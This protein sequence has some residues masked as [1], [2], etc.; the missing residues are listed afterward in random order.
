MS[1][2]A[3]DFHEVLNEELK[4]IA[5]RREV[6][7]VLSRSGTA[8]EAAG[9]TGRSASASEPP[10]KSN[11]ESVLSA[12]AAA[13]AGSSAGKNPKP[14]EASPP[15]S[16][17]PNEREQQTK[18]VL[19]DIR[20]S[21]DRALEMNLFGLAFSG[22]GIRSA[23]FNLGVIQRLA[24]HGLIRHIDYLSTVSGGGYI[25]S[26]LMAWMAREGQSTGLAEGE[27]VRNVELQL[28]PSRKTQARAER[29][30]IPQETAVP[31]EPEPV[32]HL[33]EY[34]NYL[35]PK[36]GFLSADSW[37]LIAIYLRNLLLNQL[38]LLFWAILVTLAIRTVVRAF[39]IAPIDS[40]AWLAASALV[41][42][43]AMAFYR[44][45]D[46]LMSVAD[47]RRTR[48]GIS[49]V[50]LHFFILI[51]LLLAS[52][53]MTWLLSVGAKVD[54]WGW[55]DPLLTNLDGDYTRGFVKRSADLWLSLRPSSNSWAVCPLY[56][57]SFG[58]LHG[59]INLVI[60]LRRRDVLKDKHRGR[61]AILALAGF[62][63]GIIGGLLVYL[64]CTRL[65]WPA[66]GEQFAPALLATI[67]PPLML[68]IFV[69]GAY[70]EVGLASVELGEAER[71]WWSRVCAWC[72]IYAVSWLLVIGISTFGLVG[73]AWIA[74]RL[75]QY[76]GTVW[77]V[78]TL[79]WLATTITGAF[80]GK[81]PET[82]DGR[83][84][85]GLEFVAMI[86][87]Y[88]FLVGLSIF[89][90]WLVSA[91][92]EGLPVHDRL[93]KSLNHPSI[94]RFAALSVGS[95]AIL[96]L[97][98]RRIDVNVFSLHSLYA[99]RLVRCYLGASRRKSRWS[100]FVRGGYRGGAPTHSGD[101]IRHE[102][103]VTGLDALDDFPLR[104]LTIGKNVSENIGRPKEYWGPF[105]LI[106]TAMN[107]VAG[108]ELAW[109][110]RKAESFVL[111]PL[112]CGSR[113]TGY[114]QLPPE[115]D[116][117]LSL[118][119]AVGISGAAASPNMGY[120][121]SPAVTALMTVFDVRLGWWMQNPL[122]DKWTAAGPRSGIHL[123]SELFGQTDQTSS[124]IYLSDGGHFE[125]LGIYELVRRRCRF[126]IACDASA[127]G[128]YDFE[129][130][131]GAIR[132]CR[133]DF[134]V[135]IE[136]SV[137]PIRPML[138][139]DQ[140]HWH[141]AVG[142]IAYSDVH[143]ND[144]ATTTD[145]VLVYIKSSLSGDE[146]PDILSYKES[147]P[148][149][150]HETTVDQFFNETQFESY[151]ALGDHIAGVVLGERN[152]IIPES[153]ELQ[154]PETSNDAIA[155]LFQRLAETF[156]PVPGDFAD[157]LAS[158]SEAYVALH[159]M[160]R[161]NADLQGF[162]KELY[163][164]LFLPSST[165]GDSVKRINRVHFTCQLL[166]ALENAWLGMQLDDYIDHPLNRGW[167]SIL[168]RCAKSP[169]IREDWEIVRVEFSNGFQ[170][171]FE[172]LIKN[173]SRHSIE[174]PA[175]RRESS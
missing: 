75:R 120:H 102:N 142:R 150:P 27:S 161:T 10:V 66:L 134:G 25:G 6:Q 93:W 113:P 143:G 174:D 175:G 69:I 169:L 125:N 82:K 14:P 100:N 121:S 41:A 58:G 89:V 81:R 116:A 77:S 39:S 64:A 51:P 30:E 133:S 15:N 85:R 160:L 163:G 56:M 12:M 19:D 157:R 47:T 147:H 83:G 44:I 104:Y 111:S 33:R 13:A 42:L 80:A 74:G 146:P 29:I 55:I 127:D 24:K 168:D 165:D 126:I 153:E 148:E 52:I 135:R 87:P 73:I 36:V 2:R 99:N 171:F 105:P 31:Y 96:A 128:A 8:D 154:M 57:I 3:A 98:W 122:Y 114:R 67:G 167:K 71:E 107:L 117:N 158:T 79:S 132:K 95:V 141:C 145:G 86:A 109:Q 53:S 144:G 11:T 35:S 115:A 60:A 94:S 34:S 112:F 22:G 173:G 4:L 32:F 40:L 139:A 26:W 21:Q 97:L 124:S 49:E 110:D 16:T 20:E 152:G 136:L 138:D 9:A 48:E 63:S 170:A 17:D 118:G 65:F 50:K 162:S 166:Q 70:V 1:N 130:L 5:R 172:R 156:S 28:P 59:V 18:K 151:R 123:L 101:E 159:E 38:V 68:F 61:T 103:P 149:F 92:V 129:D 45:A 43:L 108:A 76:S 78:T 46:E 164:S 54:Q 155:K 106:N 23:T 119:R 84:N 91:A 62:V 140:S 72:L 88:V 7:A 131:A 90:S 37:T 137:E